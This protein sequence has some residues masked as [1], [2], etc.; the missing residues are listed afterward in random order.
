MKSETY[1]Y[2]IYYFITIIAL[3]KSNTLSHSHRN[4]SLARKID[5]LSTQVCDNIVSKPEVFQGKGWCQFINVCNTLNQYLL[6][7]ML[8]TSL[9]C[10]VWYISAETINSLKVWNQV[11]EERRVRGWKCSLPWWKSLDFEGLYLPN[12][13]S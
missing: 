7:N 11:N 5:S 13:L 4:K 9:S 8:K 12:Y 1:W 10:P 6:V 3:V 2:V